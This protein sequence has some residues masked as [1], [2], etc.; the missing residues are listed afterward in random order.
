MPVKRSGAKTGD[1]IGVTNCFGDSGAG[2]SVLKK[3]GAEKT[4]NKDERR[5]ILRHN[6]PCARLKEAA[7]ISK[8]A[9]AMTDASDG[10]YFSVSLIAKE[11]K[12]GAS[13]D[14]EKIPMSDE[15]K[16]VIRDEKRRRDFALF[17]GEDFE[18]VFSVSP[19][20]ALALTRE[21]KGISFI[22]RINDGGGLFSERIRK[23]RK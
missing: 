6:C 21:I 11:S 13:I 20:K 7:G 2:L 10:L 3:Y 1:L 4:F 9:S 23:R 5:L 15:L 8:Y 16:N 17:G 22:G 19:R 12:K 18:L 14:L